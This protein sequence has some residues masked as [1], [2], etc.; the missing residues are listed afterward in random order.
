VEE[1][2]NPSGMPKFGRFE[3]IEELE[4]A[5]PATEAATVLNFTS[6]RDTAKFSKANT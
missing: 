3:N 5:L 4:A 1:L 2:E 6:P